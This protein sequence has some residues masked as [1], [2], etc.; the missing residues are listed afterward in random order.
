MCLHTTHAEGTRIETLSYESSPESEDNLKSGKVTQGHR[1][2][3]SCPKNLPEI[4][5]SWP[6]TFFIYVN[7]NKYK[8]YYI[9]TRNM[10]IL[11]LASK[12]HI[13]DCTR[14]PLVVV[15]IC[16]NPSE[17]SMWW[18]KYEMLIL[19]LQIKVIPDNR[20]FQKP[21]VVCFI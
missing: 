15:H 4:L 11:S 6:F 12:I 16:L 8:E 2:L 20:A 7:T 1:N 9:M 10:K 18:E 14:M 3:T 17:P 19:I 21:A 5:L 13:T